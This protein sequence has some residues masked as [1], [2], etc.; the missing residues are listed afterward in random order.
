MPWGKQNYQGLFVYRLDLGQ[1]HFFALCLLL[2]CSFLQNKFPRQIRYSFN[3]QDGRCMLFHSTTNYK[4][5]NNIKRFSI[6]NSLCIRRDC[7]VR[8]F[9]C[10]VVCR[11]TMGFEQKLSKKVYFNSLCTITRQ[12][13]HFWILPSAKLAVWVQ[14]AVNIIIGRGLK[15]IFVCIL[16]LKHHIHLIHAAFWVLLSAFDVHVRL[17]T[18][19]RPQAISQEI[20]RTIKTRN[21]SQWN[22]SKDNNFYSRRHVLRVKC[23]WKSW[24]MKKSLQI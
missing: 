22:I 24:V 20:L 2:C 15:I 3:I 17:K 16:L 14:A 13:S 10:Y 1:N 18:T 23:L 8:S 21:L 6:E 7:S 5:E 12:P 11:V 9:W 4:N 19:T